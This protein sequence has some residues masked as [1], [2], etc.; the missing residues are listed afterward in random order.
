MEF[1]VFSYLQLVMFTENCYL[2]DLQH[3]GKKEKET[4]IL[5]R[6]KGAGTEGMQSHY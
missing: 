4:K 5:L 1:E 6:G 2:N 3:E